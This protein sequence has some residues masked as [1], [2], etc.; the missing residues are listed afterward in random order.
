MQ[1]MRLLSRP[2]HDLSDQGSRKDIRG[3]QDGPIDENYNDGKVVRD[4][5]LPS[6]VTFRADDFEEFGKY[7]IIVPFDRCHNILDFFSTVIPT[8]LL[9]CV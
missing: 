6:Y 3:G 9:Y 4:D 8:S 5:T 7:G 2:F 1:A